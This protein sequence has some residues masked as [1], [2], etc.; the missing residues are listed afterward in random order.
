MKCQVSKFCSPRYRRVFT[1][2]QIKGQE[3]SGLVPASLPLAYKRV[4]ILWICLWHLGLQITLH[5]ASIN[6]IK[7]VNIEAGS[8]GEFQNARLH[9]WLE[10]C[11]T[12]AKYNETKVVSYN[13]IVFHWLHF[14]CFS[15]TV[16]GLCCFSI[17]KYNVLTSPLQ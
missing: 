11:N 15:V 8:Q 13:I 14:I 6:A 17:I 10:T 12:R 7:E 5:S 16:F 2:W 3:L 4:S 1:T 9:L